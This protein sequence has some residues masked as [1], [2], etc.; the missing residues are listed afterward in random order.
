MEREQAHVGM[1]VLFGRDGESLTVA[2][3][4]KVNP[5]RAKVIV[6]DGCESKP[7]GCKWNV[8]YALMKPVREATATEQS[9]LPN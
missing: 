4:L 1:L 9:V 3:I 6:I 5:A 8:P 2:R 7:V